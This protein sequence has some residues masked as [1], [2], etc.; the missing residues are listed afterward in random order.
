MQRVEKVLNSVDS[1]I[2]I[3]V[4]DRDDR[5]NSFEIRHR[6]V[7]LLHGGAQSMTDERTRKYKVVVNDT[8]NR[9]D[10]NR[11]ETLVND[12]ELKEEFEAITV[13][14][15]VPHSETVHN[16]ESVPLEWQLYVR[17]SIESILRTDLLMVLENLIN[18][19]NFSRSISLSPSDARSFRNSFQGNQTR[20]SMPTGFSDRQ[21]RY[22]SRPD[23]VAIAKKSL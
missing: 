11:N 6:R 4:D 22:L 19:P 10:V 21:H 12:A 18:N 1:G 13:Y 20:P 2:V 8:H 3:V 15:K 23:S 17:F 5:W 9:I 7:T 14:V 16:S